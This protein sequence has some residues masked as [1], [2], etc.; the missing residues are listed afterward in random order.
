M[1]KAGADRQAQWWRGWDDTHTSVPSAIGAA[2][3]DPSDFD[4][5]VPGSSPAQGR[6]QGEDEWGTK[7]TEG[8]SSI[9]LAHTPEKIARIGVEAVLLQWL[10]V[11]TDVGQVDRPASLPNGAATM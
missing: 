10:A 9:D 2:I 5:R 7:E 8:D 1:I 6:Q 4:K 11:P 3:F